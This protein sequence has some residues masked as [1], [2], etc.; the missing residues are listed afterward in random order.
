M[1]N[2]Q[3]IQ[4]Q[5]ESLSEHLQSILAALDEDKSETDNVS[6]DN[7]RLRSDVERLNTRL[8]AA[9]SSLS[10]TNQLGRDSRAVW[11]EF[12][13]L[14]ADLQREVLARRTKLDI[15]TTRKNI[16]DTDTI[17]NNIRET[18]VSYS[19]HT[20]FS[21]MVYWV[22]FIINIRFCWNRSPN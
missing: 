10:E 4:G 3:D 17:N 13:A 9:K 2:F 12:E 6:V 14:L 8:D 5:A 20:I 19:E 15:I 18:E 21:Q 11:D 7:A 16:L 22:C 1:L